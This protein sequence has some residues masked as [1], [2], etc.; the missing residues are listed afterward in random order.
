MNEQIIKE[1]IEAIRETADTAIR[2]IQELTYDTYKVGEIEM[3]R[4]SEQD[5]LPKDTIY[6]WDSIEGDKIQWIATDL[7]GSVWGY[8]IEPY[9]DDKFDDEWCAESDMT[10]RLTSV[11]IN[12]TVPWQE[13]LE[14]R[15]E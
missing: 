3:S 12:K 15:P 11:V 5:R 6:D 4:G 7:D 9:L 1:A 10:Y 14:K 8:P 13:S 2:S